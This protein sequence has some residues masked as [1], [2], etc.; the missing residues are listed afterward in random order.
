MS[1]L[2]TKITRGYSKPGI[3]NMKQDMR[4]THEAKS[5]T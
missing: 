2:N 3:M 5:M 4:K 1:K